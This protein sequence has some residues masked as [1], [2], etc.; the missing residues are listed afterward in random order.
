MNGEKGILSEEQAKTCIPPNHFPRLEPLDA[1]QEEG[2]ELSFGLLIRKQHGESSSLFVELLAGDSGVV[3]ADDGSHLLG[4]AGIGAKRQRQHH[5]FFDII[6]R[7]S[8]SDLHCWNGDLR[9]DSR[10]REHRER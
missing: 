3:L 8:T 10:G 4:Q 2:I 6:L 5:F 9:G 1:V 7:S